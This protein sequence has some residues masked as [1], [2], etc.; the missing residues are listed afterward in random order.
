MLI[1][2]CCIRIRGNHTLIR[3]S[4]IRDLR[5]NT[6]DTRIR[7][8]H[9]WISYSPS[10]AI[11]SGAFKLMA[12]FPVYTIFSLEVI[13]QYL[14][15]QKT[16]WSLGAG[17]GK[18]SNL[19]GFPSPSISFSTLTGVVTSLVHGFDSWRI[20][21]LMRGYVRVVVVVVI[22]GFLSLGQL[23]MAIYISV[24]LNQDDATAGVPHT[25]S[26]SLALWWGWAAAADVVVTHNATAR[27]A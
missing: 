9:T 13:F 7:V 3:G 2:G 16:W 6:H 24:Y 17:W 8:R 5:L 12:L 27:R 4:Y 1:R 10:F 15:A 18:L 21:V 11:Q 22:I 19:R 20:A 14:E 25:I 26:T 23:S